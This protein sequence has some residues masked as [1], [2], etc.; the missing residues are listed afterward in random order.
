MVNTFNVTTVLFDVAGAFVNAFSGFQGWTTL[1]SRLQCKSYSERL[2]VHVRHYASGTPVFLNRSLSEIKSSNRDAVIR[3]VNDEKMP[4]LLANLLS[5]V[6]DSDYKQACI[7][8]REH[9]RPKE[10]EDNQGKRFRKSV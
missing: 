5:A 2:L 8:I 4:F 7:E 9:V 1:G 3:I 10:A 6:E